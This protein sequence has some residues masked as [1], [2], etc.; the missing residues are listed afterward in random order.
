MILHLIFWDKKFSTQFI[1]F[2][3]SNFDKSNHHFLVFGSQVLREDLNLLNYENITTV[4]RKKIVRFFLILKYSL[5]SSKIIIHG[6]WDPIT[7]ILLSLNKKGA[8]KSYWLIWGGDLYNAYWS[9]NYSIKTKILHFFRRRVIE[10]IGHVVTLMKKEVD[11]INEWYGAEP[12][13]Y[14]CM[15]YQSNLTDD[16]IFKKIEEKEITSIMVGHSA[17]EDNNHIE[18]FEYLKGFSNIKVYSILSYGSEFYRDEVIN[19]G[20]T[21]FGDNFFPITEYKNLSEYKRLL[22]SMNI[23]IFHAKRQIGFGNLVNL[24]AQGV[25]IY[26]RDEIATKQYFDSIG[27]KTYSLFSD[28]D[29]TLI[30]SNVL[31]KNSKIIKSKHTMINLIKEWQEIFDN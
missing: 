13:V 26:L 12:N 24:V 15:L 23:A 5:K 28:V 29:V 30:D 4:Y 17:T 31:E 2:I 21:M 25:K 20:S 8:K 10:N 11:L 27:V 22:G 18:V 1:D 16:V 19:K 7:I 3:N 14:N 6:L 9:R